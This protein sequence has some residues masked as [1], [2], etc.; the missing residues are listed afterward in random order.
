MESEYTLK[1]TKVAV[2]DLDS[3]YYYLYNKIFLDSIV[4]ELL[5]KI[6]GNIL[7][8]KKFPLSCSFVSD[9]F[10]RSKGYRK[11]II[12][13]YIVFYI[14]NEVHKEVIIMRILYSKQKYEDYLD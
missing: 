1:F 12:D 10:L 11:L 4:I 13:N 3:I 14:V 8:L 9:K 6:E 5:E 2:E 7:R